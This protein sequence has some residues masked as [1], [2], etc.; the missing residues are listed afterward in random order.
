MIVAHH[1][2]IGAYAR[3]DDNRWPWSELADG[4]RVCVV[5][6]GD[7]SGESFRHQAW[8]WA[9]RHGY[10]VESRTL[11]AYALIRFAARVD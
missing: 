2:S 7:T 5:W 8:K 10:T 4:G 9:A 11:G 6:L 1:Q 3:R